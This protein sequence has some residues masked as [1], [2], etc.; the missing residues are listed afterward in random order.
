MLHK[1]PVARLKA[2][3]HPILDP[4]L[5]LPDSVRSRLSL[6]R[7]PDG[8]HQANVT[9]PYYSQFASA[10]RVCDYIHNDFDGTEDPNWRLFGA[11]EAADYVFWAP[12]ICALAVLKM[13]IEAFHPNKRLSLWQ[14]VVEGLKL[15]GYT[16]RDERGRWI[17]QG[18]YVETQIQLA[19]QYGLL[20]EPHGYVSS[21]S[22]CKLIKQ[23]WLIAAT[24]TPEIGERTLT[25]EQYGGHLVLVYGFEWQQGRP[26]HY[27]LHNPSGRF[28]ELQANARIPA[29]QFHNAFAHRLIAL[30]PVKKD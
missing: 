28:P 27:H 3:L 9:V 22:I 12:R 4:L 19:E 17:D 18:W 29:E 16:V 10:D 14:L 7:L 6:I 11:R 2:S 26:T 25:G 24:V 30:R 13:A 1:G 8:T 15:D 21:L 5:S 20:A 23:G